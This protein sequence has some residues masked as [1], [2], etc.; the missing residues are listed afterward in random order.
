MPGDTCQRHHV[1]PPGH[2]CQGTAAGIVKRKIINQQ[3]PTEF[4][5]QHRSLVRSYCKRRSQYIATMK[6]GA[7]STFVRKVV[8]Y[9]KSKAGGFGIVKSA[10]LS[11]ETCKHR[12]SVCATVSHHWDSLI[13]ANVPSLAARLAVCAAILAASL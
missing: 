4:A 6:I 5:E 11:I 7:V 10:S 9:A 12:S 13:R 8:R 2:P 3:F 1:H